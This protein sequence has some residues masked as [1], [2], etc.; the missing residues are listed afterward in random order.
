MLH[1]AFLFFL[2]LSHTVCLC[3]LDSPRSSCCLGCG[4]P[5]AGYRHDEPAGHRISTLIDPSDV[6]LGPTTARPV[7]TL[8]QLTVLPDSWGPTASLLACRQTLCFGKSQRRRSGRETDSLSLFLTPS[9]RGNSTPGLSSRSPVIGPLIR[10]AA[11]TP[12]VPVHVLYF[13]LSLD[14][15]VQRTNIC[16]TVP[17]RTHVTPRSTS[18]LDKWPLLPF[19]LSSCPLSNVPTAET[20]SLDLQAT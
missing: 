7:C 20:L 5:Q 15:Y 3:P 12:F 6:L 9:R 10:P 16:L 11:S 8:F 19:P 17:V 18:G 14:C 2:A 1:G 4:L 13:G